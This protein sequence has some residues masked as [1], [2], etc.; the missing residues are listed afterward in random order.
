MSDFQFSGEG[1]YFSEGAKLDRGKL[2]ETSR[3]VACG[4]SEC[5]SEGPAL[6]E[7]G[8]RMRNQ[9]IP[10]APDAHLS[11]WL[12][13][14]FPQSGG[15]EVQGSIRP[16]D[17]TPNPK[18]E[19]WDQSQALRFLDDPAPG[20]SLGGGFEWRRKERPGRQRASRQSSLPI[21]FTELH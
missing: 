9:S 5:F 20:C 15:C 8:Q 7:Q 21:V 2:H 1:C 13:D 12:W 6:T 10:K 16:D 11:L 14:I 17:G 18:L 3:G 4:R 19:P